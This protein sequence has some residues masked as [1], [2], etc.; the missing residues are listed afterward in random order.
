VKIFFLCPDFP[1]PSGGTK[2][3]YWYVAQ[4]RKQGLNACIVHQK[5]GFKL[6]W[7]GIDAPTISLADHP[8]LNLD[9]IIVFTEVMH[10]LM[11][12]FQ[13]TPVCKVVLALNWGSHY[14]KLEAEDNWKNYGISKV[15]TPAPIISNYIQ[16]RMKLPCTVID[17]FLDPKVYFD[18][19]KSKLKKISYMS[20]KTV[21]GEILRSTFTKHP[22]HTDFEWQAL[23]NFSEKDYAKHLQQSAIYL[24][25]YP[26]EGL[27]ISVLEAMA[28]GCLVVGYSGVGGSDYMIGKGEKQNCILVENGNLP[29]FGTILD[30][31]LSQ[32]SNN[33]ASFQMI[34]DQAIQTASR[35]QNKE[36]EAKQLGDFFK[37]LPTNIGKNIIQ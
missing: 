31:I 32:W 12:Q 5:S 6:T 20:R 37:S 11:Q 33:P 25:L 36:K 7:H 3:L 18:N 23:K 17:C 34:I 14:I 15:F 29:A 21:D 9:D 28:C 16:W 27:N 30:E 8:E 19:K 13:S 2:T 22:K 10:S 35:F 24:P 4:L 1:R 26:E